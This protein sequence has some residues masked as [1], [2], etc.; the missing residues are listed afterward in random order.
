MSKTLFVSDFDDTLAQTDAKIIITKAS[1]EVVEMDPP[2]YAVYTPEPGDKFDF[3]EFE[4]LKNPR[5]IRRFVQL[6]KRAIADK[7]VDKIAILTARGHTKPVAPAV[8]G[9]RKKYPEVKLLVHQAKEH[10]EEK[11]TTPTSPDNNP[12]DNNTDSQ[13]AIQAKQMGLEDYKFGR[14]GKNGTVTHTVQNGRLLP[15]PKEGN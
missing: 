15:K 6:L 13:I 7:R 3:S 14:Y 5:P 12:A 9:L 10:P 1:G 8:E 11:D 2:D 4:K